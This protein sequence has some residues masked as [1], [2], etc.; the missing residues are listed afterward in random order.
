V[1]A[2][3]VI[4]ENVVAFEVAAALVDKFGGDSVTEMRARWDLYHELARGR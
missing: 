4:V 1:S 2:C 3:S